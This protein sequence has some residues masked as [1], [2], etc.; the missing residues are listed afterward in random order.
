VCRESASKDFEHP[1]YSVFL[2]RIALNRI[3]SNKSSYPF[4]MKQV[5][6]YT[7]DKEYSHF[8]ELVKN[9]PYVKKIEADDTPTKEDVLKNIKTGLEEVKKF[10][11][12]KL[13]ITSAKD[14]LDEL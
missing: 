4:I 6:V 11:R 8:V 13:K 1:M 9:L 7:T 2:N 10:Q 3:A 14:F 12:G 5:T